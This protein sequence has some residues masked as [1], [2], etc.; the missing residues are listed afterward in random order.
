[1][2]GPEV[3]A[4]E[5]GYRFKGGDPKQESSWEQVAPIDVSSDY[6]PGARRYPNGTLVRVGP[7]GGVT[8][9]TNTAA[10]GGAASGSPLVGA[11]ARARYMIGLGP[12]QDAKKNFDE[13]EASGNPIDRDWGAALIDRATEVPFLSRIGDTI[14][15]KVGGEDYQKYV[16]AASTY[17][18]AL[19]P[20]LSG[21]AVTESEALR[22]IRADLPQAGDS[23]EVLQRKARNRASRINA[24]AE[25]IGKPAPYDLNNLGATNEAEALASIAGGLPDYKGIKSAVMG[26][27]GGYDIGPDGNPIAPTPDEPTPGGSPETAIDYT[28]TTPDQLL[29]L[30]ANG[31]WVRQGD[32]EPYQVAAGSVTRSAG[33][34]E[35]APGV[36]VTDRTDWTPEGAV[37]QRREMWNPARQV[38]A[39]VRGAADATSLEFADEI[40]AGADALVGRGNGRTIGDRYRNNVR[41]QRAIDAADGEDA[42]FARNAG[43]VAGYSVAALTQGPRLLA[44]GARRFGSPLLNRAVTGVRNA[45]TGGAVAATAAAGQSEGNALQRAQEGLKAAPVGAVVG[46]ALPVGFA[47]GRGADG[48]IGSPVQKTANAIG[49]VVGA[50]GERLGIRSASGLRERNTPNALNA[51]VEQFGARMGPRRVSALQENVNQQRLMGFT[52]TLADAVDDAGQGQ[53]RAL[54]SLDTSARP[55]AVRFGR[56]RRAAAQQDVSNIARRF[57]SDDPRTATRVASDLEDAQRAASGPAYEAA[58]AS[59]PI[60]VTADV[61]EALFSGEGPATIRAAGRAYKSSVKPEER[62]LALELEG[63]AQAADEGMPAGEVQLSV[64]AADLLSRYLAKAGG[65]DAN[66]SRI[67]QGLGREIRNQARAQAPAYDAALSGY[68]ERAQLDDAADFGRRFLNRRGSQDFADQASAMLPAQRD[69]ARVAARDAIEDAGSTT[70]G[71]ATLLD[72]LSIGR[73]TGQRADALVNDPEAMRATAEAARMRLQTG[74]NVDPRMGS[75]T[76]LNRQ[77]SDNVDGAIEF[78]TD[79]ARIVASPIR[80]TIDVVARR[81]QNRGFSRTEAEELVNAAI[82]PNRTDELVR[83]LS[84]RMSRREARTLARAVQRQVS[85][86]S[87]SSSAEQ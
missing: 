53:L 67:Y 70:G 29:A 71:A 52:P 38:D 8:P 47:I 3:G 69:V 15:R 54:S 13:A 20:I 25:G 12:L 56:E 4:I 48:L 64:G 60:T 21:A 19:L 44:Q 39:F 85:S 66:L 46:A 50:G 82:D 18:S 37:A 11:D 2:A 27:T 62:A 40:A 1:M 10:P 58:R 73:G 43:E 35:V 34:R 32:G 75:N 84:Q 65:N 59:P 57:V 51:A 31:G 61:G 55:N 86:G 22:L 42:A 5:D 79:G 23:E 9:I 6:G 16:Q 49:R 63:L 45:L 83:M 26:V 68:A 74:R 28:K 80:G 24:V 81:F 33:G 17:E 72:D 76:N 78:L 87:G 14:A 30:L 7:K 41:V 77:D 36:N